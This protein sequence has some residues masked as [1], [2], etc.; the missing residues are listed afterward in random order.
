MSKVVSTRVTPDGGYVVVKFD[1]AHE[2]SIDLWFTPER[3]KEAD[4]I[5]AESVNWPGTERFCRA[6]AKRL[7]QIKLSW[8][9]G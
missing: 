8:M 4:Q 7:E 3:Q 2:E 6:C 5:R 9:M 1:C